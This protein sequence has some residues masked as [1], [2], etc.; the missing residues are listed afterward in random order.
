M[1]QTAIGTFQLIKQAYGDNILSHTR[2]FESYARFQDG[3]DN[4]KDDERIGQPTANQTPDMIETVRELISTDR[5]MTLWMMEEEVL[6]HFVERIRRV[7]PQFQERGSWFLLH[8]NLRPHTAISIKQFLAKH[9][10]PELNHP[11]YS[12]DLSPPDFFLF[13]KIKS[14]L[15]GRRFE[16]KESI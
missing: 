11:P 10:I 13:P 4:L 7:R 2:V 3:S 8:D 9:G 14:T 16:D 6:S 12:P 5:Q 15:K 1:G